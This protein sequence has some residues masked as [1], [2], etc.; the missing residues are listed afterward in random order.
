LKDAVHKIK[1]TT[2]GPSQGTLMD[3]YI[4]TCIGYS[5]FQI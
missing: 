3:R 2:E 4:Y 5:A 1:H